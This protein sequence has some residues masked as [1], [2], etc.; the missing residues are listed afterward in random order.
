MDE[1][2]QSPKHYTQADISVA[3]W[4]ENHV[5]VHNSCIYRGHADS[6]I[7]N[8]A[9]CPPGHFLKTVVVLLGS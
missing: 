5:C 7:I 9:D 4:Q 6:S 1:T 3:S 2:V 8:V